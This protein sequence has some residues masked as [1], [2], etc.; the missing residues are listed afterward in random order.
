MS[1]D[2][3]QLTDPNSPLLAVMSFA[4]SRGLILA[5][6]ADMRRGVI[7]A[8]QA[9][10][11]LAGMKMLHDNIQTEINVTKLCIQTEGRAHQFGKAVGMG[12]R[13]LLGD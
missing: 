6:I 3:N 11:I 1:T 2:N 10:A 5:T 4:D 12:K 9:M 13:K 7:P 8:A